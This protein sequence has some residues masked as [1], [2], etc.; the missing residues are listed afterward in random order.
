MTP[1]KK[2]V[3]KILLGYPHPKFDAWLKKKGIDRENQTQQE[4]LSNVCDFFR[5]DKNALRQ[6]LVHGYRQLG[7]KELVKDYSYVI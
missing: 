7:H 5:V 6:A 4:L 3:C 1:A 2:V